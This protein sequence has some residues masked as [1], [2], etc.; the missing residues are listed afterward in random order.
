MEKRAQ[1][2]RAEEIEAA[3]AEGREPTP[4]IELSTAEEQNEMD[5]YDLLSD[6][7][8][9]AI[10]YGYIT[11][12][13]VAFPIAPALA[14]V[15]NYVELRVDAKKLLTRCC[16]PTPAGAEDLGTWLIVLDSIS[17]VAVITNSA[18]V[19]FTAATP[20]FGIPQQYYVWAFVVLEHFVFMLKWAVDRFVPDVPYEV[21]LQLDRQNYLVKKHI[22]GLDVDED[23]KEN[24]PDEE[25]EDVAERVELGAAVETEEIEVMM[26]PRGVDRTTAP[27]SGK[28]RRRFTIDPEDRS[29]AAL[30][31]AGGTSEE[32]SE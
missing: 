29:T 10:Q 1:K 28:Q 2:A 5:D 20:P 7:A 19:V 11:L 25:V 26:T 15:S 16:R 22:E 27:S 23:A 18:A 30:H 13:V 4:E 3:A 12:F 17:K 21:S 24:V 8:E 6:Y 31:S 9:M 32:K 14:L